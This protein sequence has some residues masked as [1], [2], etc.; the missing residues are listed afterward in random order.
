MISDQALEFKKNGEGV[1]YSWATTEPH[2]YDRQDKISWKWINENTLTIK[3][4]KPDA[5]WERISYKIKH[6]SGDY[7]VVYKR[8]TSPDFKAD[9]YFK[10]GFWKV[11]YL[12]LQPYL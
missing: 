11:I 2:P 12:L 7:G 9:T 5:E 3:E 1:Y 10:E 6:Y 8:M 4:D